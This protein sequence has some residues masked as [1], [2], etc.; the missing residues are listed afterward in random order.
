MQR[1]KRSSGMEENGFVVGKKETFV[2]RLSIL[3]EENG[4]RFFS[5]FLSFFSNVD[6]SVWFR[7][8]SCP[9]IYSPT[10]SGMNE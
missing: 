2:S 10:S 5:V 4:Y 9:I 6:G 8:A 3:S 7:T 1:L